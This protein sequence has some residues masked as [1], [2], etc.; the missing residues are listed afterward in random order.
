MRRASVDFSTILRACSR[1][2]RLLQH[3]AEPY[4]AGTPR[5]RIAGNSLVLETITRGQELDLERD[6]NSHRC[7]GG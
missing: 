4:P 6:E 1:R 2:Q 3:S 5:R 7:N